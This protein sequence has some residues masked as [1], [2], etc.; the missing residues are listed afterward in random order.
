MTKGLLPGRSEAPGKG[1]YLFTTIEALLEW[2]DIMRGIGIYRESMSVLEITLPRGW[3]LTPDPEEPKE[4]FI[5]HRKIP[6]TLVRVG[7]VPGR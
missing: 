5:S 3:I 4:S 2:F 7:H 6:G 1:I